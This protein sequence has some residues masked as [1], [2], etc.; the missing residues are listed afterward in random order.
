[1]NENPLCFQADIFA[2]ARWIFCSRGF[3]HDDSGLEVVQ[4][5]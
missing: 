1:M 2:G 4:N 5:I 3:N